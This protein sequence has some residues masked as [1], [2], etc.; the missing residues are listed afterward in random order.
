MVEAAFFYIRLPAD[1]LDTDVLIAAG[2]KQ[3]LGGI[4]Q[5]LLCLV[6]LGHAANL[7]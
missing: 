4:Q 2:V 1:F 7:S 3:F 5:A 6:C